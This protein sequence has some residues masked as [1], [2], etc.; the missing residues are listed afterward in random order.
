MLQGMGLRAV[1][2]ASKSQI[3]NPLVNSR[4]RAQGAIV[5]AAATK[6]KPRIMRLKKDEIA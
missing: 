1:N 3:L 5:V 2:F 4:G 6:V